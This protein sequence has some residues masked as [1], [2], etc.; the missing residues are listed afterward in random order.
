MN[1]GIGGIMMN[2]GVALYLLATGILGFGS[3]SAFKSLNPEIRQAVESIFDKGDFREVLIVILSILAVAAGAFIILRMLNISIPMMDLILIILAIVW[4]V[5][6]VMIDIVA[7][8]RSSR[9]TNFV[10]WMLSFSSH[11][12]ILA[13]ILLSTEKFGG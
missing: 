7:P 13:G 10:N 8:I 11:I 5:F 12:I 4:V 2:A 3:R 1:R 6:I 9:D